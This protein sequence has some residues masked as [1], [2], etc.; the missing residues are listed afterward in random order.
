MKRLTKKQ[1]RF[2]LST[3][4]DY[5]VHPRDPY[6]RNMAWHSKEESSWGPDETEVK[7]PGP[8]D[9]F[10]ITF[11]VPSPGPP[12]L[13]V[14]RFRW[15][16]ESMPSYRDVMPWEWENTSWVPAVMWVKAVNLLASYAFGSPKTLSAVPNGPA[17]D[18]FVVDKDF[19]E[20]STSLPNPNHH[21]AKFVDFVWK[22]AESRTSCQVPVNLILSSARGAF[23]E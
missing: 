22:Y 21:E 23:H 18:Q 14:I 8:P 17:I 12:R 5:F 1:M 19:T 20:V 4:L 15:N 6:R 2:V 13:S 7:W 11:P 3:P 9:A 16:E 10:Q